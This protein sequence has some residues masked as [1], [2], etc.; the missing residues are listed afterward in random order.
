[1]PRDASFV[2]HEIEQFR[3]ERFGDQ[4]GGCG[5]LLELLGTLAPLGDRC[6]RGDKPVLGI[7]R[8]KRQAMPWSPIRRLA[9][10]EPVK[11]ARPAGFVLSQAMETGSWRSFGVQGDRGMRLR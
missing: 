1:V 4:C 9:D 3:A 11:G 2:L 5:K 10:P 6:R 7:A 8:T